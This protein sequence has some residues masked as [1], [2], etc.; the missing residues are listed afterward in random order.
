MLL[1]PKWYRENINDYITLMLCVGLVLDSK[2]MQFHIFA[3]ST[4]AYA[5]I[6]QKLTPLKFTA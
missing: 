3:H 1:I 6:Q 5:S 2:N 4:T